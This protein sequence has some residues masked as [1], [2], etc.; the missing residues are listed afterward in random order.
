MFQRSLALAPG[1]STSARTSFNFYVSVI[2]ARS[3]S[4][5]RKLPRIEKAISRS[6][7]VARQIPAV[8]AKPIFQPVLRTVA[9][10]VADYSSGDVGRYCF[11][12]SNQPGIAALRFNERKKLGPLF[13]GLGIFMPYLSIVDALRSG[14]NL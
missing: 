1:S 13:L 9:R 6:G 5:C 7:L 10:S 8:Q 2:S 3:W 12:E 11:N 4:A 14:K